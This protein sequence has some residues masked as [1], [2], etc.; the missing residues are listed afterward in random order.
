MIIPCGSIETALYVGVF[1]ETAL[2]VGVFKE[3]GLRRHVCNSTKHLNQIDNVDIGLY[4]AQV[5]SQAA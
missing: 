1:K 5:P 2:Y 3:P 4:K